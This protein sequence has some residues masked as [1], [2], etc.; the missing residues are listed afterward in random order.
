[1]GNL[2]YGEYDKPG[3]MYQTKI[4]KDVF[5]KGL[6]ERYKPQ[7]GQPYPTIN[8]L[9][10]TDL[11]RGGYYFAGKC[12]L[13]KVSLYMITEFAGKRDTTLSTRTYAP[14]IEWDNPY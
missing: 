8:I 9:N 7:N 2:I 13:V 5:F 6:M 1:M 4:Q 14:R 10:N 3:S 12:L 11:V